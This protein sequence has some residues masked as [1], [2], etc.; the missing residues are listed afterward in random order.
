M[1]GTGRPRF[2]SST[3]AITAR[4]RVLFPDMLAPV[5]SMMRCPRCTSFKTVLEPGSSAPEVSAD[6]SGA[7]S[8]LL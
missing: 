5:S 4:I 3:T 2:P 7:S 1:H 6:A 8:K